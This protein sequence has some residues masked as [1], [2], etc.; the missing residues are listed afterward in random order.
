MAIKLRTGQIDTEQR[1]A[2]L[3]ILAR[4]PEPGRCLS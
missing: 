2:A 3:A 4:M 1:A